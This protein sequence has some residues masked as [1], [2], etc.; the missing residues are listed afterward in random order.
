[1][2]YGPHFTVHLVFIGYGTHVRRVVS[3]MFRCKSDFITE[4][5]RPFHRILGQTF[6]L[7]VFTISGDPAALLHCSLR[8][9]FHRSHTSE[10]RRQRCLGLVCPCSSG[11][12]IRIV[13]RVLQLPSNGHKR[14]EVHLYAHAMPLSLITLC[15]ASDPTIMK[16]GTPKHRCGT[17][18]KAGW[19]T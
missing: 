2:V 12:K 4:I 5:G 19:E 17:S 14:V 8:S 7:Q 9:M 18:L 3:R 15:W 10:R 13:I 1:M 11:F 16:L 6:F